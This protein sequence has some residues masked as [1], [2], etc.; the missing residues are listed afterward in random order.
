VSRPVV[1]QPVHVVQKPGS[2]TAQSA[3]KGASRVPAR[4]GA[5]CPQ[6]E[7]AAQE[8]AHAAHHGCPVVLE[9]MQGPVRP[10][11]L[12][13][14]MVRGVHVAQSGPFGVRV[15]TRWRRPQPV[16]SSRLSGSVTTQCGHNGRPRS[17]RAAGSRTV[18]HVAHATTRARA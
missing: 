18:P 5:T 15:L 13:V 4:A 2:G 10:H 8:R 12:Q 3:H 14:E 16:Q 9:I 6:R 1:P 7:H 11:M 17:S